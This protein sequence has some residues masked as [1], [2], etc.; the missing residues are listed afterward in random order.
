MFGRRGRNADDGLYVKDLDDDA[1]PRRIA[2]LPPDDIRTFLT[3]F[4]PDG[5]GVI[6]S[7]FGTDQKG[8]IVFVALPAEASALSELTPVVSGPG[9]EVGGDISPDGRWIVYESDESGRPEIYVA[10]FRPGAR[11][12][13]IRRVTTTGGAGPHWS[14]DGR[15]LRYLDPSGRV[16][17]APVTLTPTLSFGPAKPLFDTNKLNL[18]VGDILADGRQLAI[19][20]GEEE[21]DEVR[22]LALALNFT[23]EI[24][25]KMK[26]AG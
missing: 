21:S 15:Q 12:T 6:A 8:D 14:P 11:A 13:Q 26:G 1:P 25:E 24:R 16:M 4:A 2:A 3:S 10:A 5:S 20:R 22:R 19:L 18:F 17:A 23:S 7:R 9:S